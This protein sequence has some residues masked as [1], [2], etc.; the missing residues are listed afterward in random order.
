M[1]NPFSFAELRR[2]E[3]DAAIILDGTVCDLVE[4][5]SSFTKGPLQ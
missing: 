2:A 3:P 1:R 5:L 4:R